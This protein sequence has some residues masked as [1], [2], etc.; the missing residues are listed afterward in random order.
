MGNR[1]HFKFNMTSANHQV[2]ATEGMVRSVRA[3]LNSMVMKLKNRLDT[4][5]LK[6]FFYETRNIINSCPLTASAANNPEDNIITPNRILTMKS[7]V[8]LAPPPGNFT[9]DHSH[10]TRRWKAAQHVAEV[11]W[12]AWRTEYLQTITE[13][14][15]WTKT[16]ENIKI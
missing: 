16:V 15:K 11:F 2:G 8:L 12:K 13:R 10:S 6:T 3:V 5:L 9:E 4:K 7:K 1:I 14:Q